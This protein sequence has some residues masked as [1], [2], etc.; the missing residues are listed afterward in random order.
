MCWLPVTGGV[1]SIMPASS[2]DLAASSP[3]PSV[4]V[5]RDACHEAGTIGSV[6]TDGDGGFYVLLKPH[7]IQSRREGVAL[8]ER[9]TC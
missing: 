2:P 4:G 5:R 3:S 8:G 1:Q 6:P 7:Q 9:A